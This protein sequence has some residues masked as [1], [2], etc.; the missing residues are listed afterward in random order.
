MCHMAVSKFL[1]VRQRSKFQLNSKLKVTLELMSECQNVR[2][3]RFGNEWTKQTHNKV[4]NYKNCVVLE[5]F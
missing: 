3:L 1:I 4:Y 5:E 2:T